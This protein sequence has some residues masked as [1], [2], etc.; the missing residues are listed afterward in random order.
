MLRGLISSV[1]QKCVL[2]NSRWGNGTVSYKL[3]YKYRVYSTRFW[4]ELQLWQKTLGFDLG[5]DT[6][7]YVQI[8]VYVYVFVYKYQIMKKSNLIKKSKTTDESQSLGFY[9][10]MRKL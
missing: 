4:P 5:L 10:K 9:N 2:N 7:F 1:C 3:V 8:Y 6:I